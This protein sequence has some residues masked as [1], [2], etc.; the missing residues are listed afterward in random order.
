[1]ENTRYC[2]G[3][4]TNVGCGEA[5]GGI[6]WWIS[7]RTGKYKYIRWLVPGEIEEMY[8]LESDPEELVNLA[9]EAEY[10][11]LLAKCRQAAIDEL[12]RTDA[13][14]VDNLPPV[15]VLTKEQLSAVFRS[16][17]ANQ[18]DVA[19]EGFD[20]RFVERLKHN[21]VVRATVQIAGN[22]RRCNSASF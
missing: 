7:L 20:E 6:P 4:Y 9:L 16:R 11:E 17:F 15:M 10:H 14:M 21:P 22:W 3:E 19:G 12:R 5:E 13:G 1:M 8:D 2:F 18:V